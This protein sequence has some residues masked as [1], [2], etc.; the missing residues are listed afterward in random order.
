MC[1]QND[2]FLS[3][4]LI[5]ASYEKPRGF[6]APTERRPQPGDVSCLRDSSNAIGRRYKENHLEE[7]IARDAAAIF[8]HKVMLLASQNHVFLQER[9]DLLFIDGNGM[10]H[11]VEAKIKGMQQNGGV[12]PAEIYG[13]M[14]RYIQFLA[15]DGGSFPG[16][17]ESD[18]ARFSNRFYG[19]EHALR[20]D[21]EQAFGDFSVAAAVT[22]AQEVYLA[23]QFDAYAR[24][25][26]FTWADRDGRNV[27]LVY[28]RFYPSDHYIEFWEACK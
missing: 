13:Q 9:V 12:V 20:D 5:A 27:R 18:Y 2:R 3:A 24:D 6:L 28:F 17:M 21:L 25:R 11:V 1:V 14:G 16:G 23:A 10:F 7:W 22:E 26:L 4:W 19:A 8:P 15:Q